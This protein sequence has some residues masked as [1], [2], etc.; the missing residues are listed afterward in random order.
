MKRHFTISISLFF[1]FL[2]SLILPIIPTMAQSG[3]VVLRSD[4]LVLGLMPGTRGA[5]SV[6]V[7]N[8]H[9]LYGLE[10]R[11]VFDPDIVEIIDT[12]LAEDGIQIK[13]AD[14]WKGGFVA[15]NQADNQSGRIDFAATLLNPS[16]PVQGDQVV[17]VITFAAN[18]M[19][20]SALSIESAILSTRDAEEIPYMKQEGGIGVN[21][22]GQAPAMG[23]IAELAEPF[24]S[25][26]NTSRFVL[27]GL[28]TLAF[29]AALGVFIYVLR[30]R[31]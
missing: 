11:L 19:G 14:W 7:E 25:T 2:T 18:N 20:I 29:L 5:V 28:S 22:S 4:P 3:R 17:A 27:A 16:S 9:D 26:G 15:I 21:P 8:V 24:P 31:R 13:P 6:V 12:D 30:R 10:F 23:A 1:A